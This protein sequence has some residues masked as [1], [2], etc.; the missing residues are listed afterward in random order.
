[1]STLAWVARAKAIAHKSFHDNGANYLAD[2]HAPVQAQRI[3]KAA[4]GGSDAASMA[5]YDITV[6]AWSDSAR[7]SS[8]F[9][10]VWADNGFIKLPFNTKVGLVTGAASGAKVDEGKAVPVSKVVLGNVQLSPTRVAALCVCTDRLLF[11]VDAAGQATFN[12][13]LL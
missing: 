1:V 7:T 9:F 4:V 10:R 6:G 2:N 3:F 12:R 5:P 8:A 11:T 13:E